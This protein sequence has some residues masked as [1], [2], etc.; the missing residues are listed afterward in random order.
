M[1]ASSENRRGDRAK[2]GADLKREKKEA[3]WICFAGVAP[4]PS[5]T[6]SVFCFSSETGLSDFFALREKKPFL[7][8]AGAGEEGS[9]CAMSAFSFVEEGSGEL[10]AIV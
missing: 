2:G 6:A 4:A 8:G 3:G 5:I 9:A 1:T 10:A 7:A